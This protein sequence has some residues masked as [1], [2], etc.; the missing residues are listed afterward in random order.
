[1][2]YKALLF[3]LLIGAA[4][5]ATP[6]LAVHAAKFEPAGQA[7]DGDGDS[8]SGFGSRIAGSYLSGRFARQSGNIDAAIESLQRVHEEQPENMT[9]AQQL[10]G[11]LLVQGRVEEAISIAEDIDKAGHKDPLSTLLLAVQEL[12]ADNTESASAILDDASD[13]GHTQL[14]LPLIQAW[15]DIGRHQFEKPLT[16]ERISGDVGRAAPLINYHLALINSQAGFNDE[17]ARNYKNAI[18]DPRDPPMRVMKQLLRFYDQND[19]PEQLAALVKEFR[20]SNTHE[21][22]L[23]VENDGNTP[24]ISGVRDGVAEILYTMGGIM[25]GAGVTNDAAIYLQLALYVKPDLTEAMVALGD[26]YSQLRQEKHANEMYARVPA[27]NAL[28]SKAQL[29]IA[30]NHERMGN[31]KEAI[32]LLDR[33][34]AKSGSGPEALVTKGDLLRIHAR[35][36]EAIQAYTAA[37]DRIGELKPMYWPLLFARGSCYERQGKWGLAEKDLLMALEIKPDQPDV[38]NY[39]GFSWLERGLHMDEARDMI[40][41]AVKER[42]DDAQIVD[43]MGWALYMGGDYTASISYLEKAVELLPGDPTVNDHLGDVYWRLGRRNEAR[44]QW[45]RAL[46]FS[47][48]DKL[49]DTIRKKLKDG[50]PADHFA[51]S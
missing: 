47:P 27:D 17:A 2:K 14:W 3:S 43:S 41:R 45:E 25:F 42:P 5:V 29:H 36:A 10:Q 49:A 37:L 32:A 16:L 19:A 30:I 4:L 38:L 18:Q 15:I 22:E 9:V 12:S 7:K 24:V 48:D 13:S 50:L 11:M 20:E 21:G 23:A 44:F 34:N 46:T 39:L 31:L 1:M 6:A 35:H 51:S 33:M 26:A 8:D 28:Y 40:A